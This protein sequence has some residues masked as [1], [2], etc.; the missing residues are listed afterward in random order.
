MYKYETVCNIQKILLD[1][2]VFV[3]VLYWFGFFILWGLLISSDITTNLAQGAEPV[4]AAK[5]VSDA[6]ELNTDFLIKTGISVLILVVGYLMNLAINS[7]IKRIEANSKIEEKLTATLSTVQTAV[8][9][10]TTEMK[11]QRQKNTQ[12]EKD[13][14]IHNRRLNRLDNRL[15]H[16]DLELTKIKRKWK[17]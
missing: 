16:Q 9:G 5:T 14:A 11:F 10:L 12:Y 1:M 8:N 7:V 13:I 4:V 6:K 17:S 3:K 2:S 15:N